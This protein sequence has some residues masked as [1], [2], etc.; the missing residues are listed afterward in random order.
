ME[1]NRMIH[2]ILCSTGCLIGRP[3]GRNYH[4]IREYSGSLQCDGLE[5]MMYEDWYCEVTELL[6]Y[7]KELPWDIPVMHCQKS[8]GE[9]ISGGDREDLKKALEHFAVNCHIA[10][11]IGAKKLVMHLWDGLTSD[12]HFENNLCAYAKVQSIAESYGLELLIEN[13]VCAKGDPLTHFRQLADVYPGVSFVFDTKMAAFHGQ[14]ERLDSKEFRWLVEENRI[15][16]F[17]VNDYNGGYMEWEKLK[18][19]PIG[20][21]NINFERFFQWIHEMHY[22]G[23]FTVEATAFRK[24]G[25]VDG[26]MLNDCFE[27]IRQYRKRR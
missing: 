22:E 26:A 16:H 11:E 13:V 25:T 6:A 1:E 3:N 9:Q 17:H 27:K 5:F 4:L 12:R 24:D 10:K 23:D 19:L 21:G 7:L 14:M 15:H 8:I 20:K 18:T 2:R